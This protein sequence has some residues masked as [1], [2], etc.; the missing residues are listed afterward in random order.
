MQREITAKEVNSPNAGGV[1]F[2]VGECGLRAAGGAHHF[3]EE[4]EA[5]SGIEDRI[6]VRG[7]SAGR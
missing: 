5:R 2:L 1:P 7:I 6:V 4:P 3:S